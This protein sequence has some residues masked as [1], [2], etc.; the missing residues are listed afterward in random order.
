MMQVVF[1]API[2]FPPGTILIED[3][4]FTE[5]TLAAVDEIL[6]D[7]RCPH[8][9]L[10]IESGQTRLTCLIHLGAPHMAGLLEEG[11]YSDIPLMDF[12]VRA[13]QLV[14]ARVRLVGCD[15][16]L[17]LLA[18]I[19]FRKQPVMQ[20]STKLVDIDH[21]LDVLAREAADAVMALERDETRTLLFFR[22]GLPAALYFGDPAADPGEGDLRERF[23]LSCLDP[24]AGPGKFEVFKNLALTP[25]PDAGMTLARLAEDVQTPPAMSIHVRLGTRDLFHRPFTPPAMTIGRD[26]TCDLVVDNLGISR[27]HARLSWNRVRFLIEDLG[28]ANGTTL[29]G[30]P[31]TRSVVAAGDHIGLGKFELSLVPSAERSSMDGTI[32]M[33]AAADLAPAY[34]IG[35]GVSVPLRQEL[36]IGSS[37]KADLAARGWRVREDHAR[38]WPD[39]KG[40]IR[41]TCKPSAKVQLNDKPVQDA[42]IHFGD[43]IEIGRTTFWLVP[44]A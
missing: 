2:Q 40:A 33:D 14:G 24:A 25:D 22:Q 30:K 32:M 13:R 29:N 26:P 11:V 31:A 17:V 8:G 35:K 15:P 5:H 19:H 9:R 10:E 23:L 20:A 4:P 18:G 34:L 41:L 6:A 42:T 39:E 43:K 38:I 21:V 16:T 37:P 36:T 27:R 28:S 44:R 7:D 3:V 1:M 12:P